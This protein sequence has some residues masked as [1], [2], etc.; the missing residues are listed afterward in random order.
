MGRLEERVG[1]GTGLA[2]GLAWVGLGLGAAMLGAPRRVADLAG[3]PDDEDIRQA[4]LAV[5]LREVASGLGILLSRD[6]AGWVKARAGGDAMDIALLASAYASPRARNDR[7]SLALAA[8]LGVAALDLL[9]ARQ[10]DRRED[11]GAAGF[12]GR[13][14]TV[15]RITIRRWPGDLYAYWRDFRNL[16]R[17]MAHVQSVEPTGGDRSYWRVS[18]PMG[19]SVEWESVVVR[20]EPGR[21][22]AWR[23]LPGADVENAGTVRFEPVG[24]GATRVCVEME[25][26]PPLGSLGKAVATLFGRDP[27]QTVRDDLIFLKGILEAGGFEHPSLAARAERAPAMQGA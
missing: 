22:I 5:G 17:F 10:L 7:V 4:L 8:V 11:A 1:D 24:D 13:Y 12:D 27:T 14:R 6:P 21:L 15:E 18:G 2:T 25:Y 9:C 19:T 20:D 23:S 16:S 3:L 26:Q